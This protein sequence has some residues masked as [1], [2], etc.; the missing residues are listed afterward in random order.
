MP[1]NINKYFVLV[2]LIVISALF[3][4]PLCLSA[5]EYSVE[6]IINLEKKLN[7][8]KS[9]IYITRYMLSD[10]YKKQNSALY[11]FQKKAWRKG[12]D[13]ILPD[14]AFTSECKDYINILYG[15]SMQGFN[16]KKAALH[17]YNKVS[18][19]SSHYAEA[20]LNIALLYM[21]EGRINKTFNTIKN[22][23]SNSSV[24]LNQQI[25]NRLFLILGYL[26]LKEKRYHESRVAFRNIEAKSIY[27][28]RGV[29]GASIAALQL[30]DYAASQH[31]LFF[32]NRKKHMIF[33]VMSHILL[34]HF[35]MSHRE[36]MLKPQYFSKMLLSIIKKE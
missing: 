1:F 36:N 31:A 11:Y 20:Q 25:K 29:I 14:T 5:K 15:I 28:N 33:P 24:I 13:S 35:L 32:L 27:F 6:Y 26:N 9:E 2:K 21:H 3:V 17:Y 19:S 12:L 34:W 22:I 4:I 23:L 7:T 8:L 18:L 10:N 30:K 16:K